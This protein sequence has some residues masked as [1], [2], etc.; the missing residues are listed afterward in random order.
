MLRLVSVR[1]LVL[2]DSADSLLKIS[3]FVDAQAG[4]DVFSGCQL[5]VVHFGFPCGRC[6]NDRLN[7]SVSAYA[8]NHSFWIFLQL[9]IPAP[10]R[11]KFSTHTTSQV[12]TGP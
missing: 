1:E 7:G 6:V 11:R 10:K 4:V 9:A 5:E 8:V 2:D 3:G 12:S